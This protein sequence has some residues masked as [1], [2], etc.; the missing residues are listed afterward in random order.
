[1]RNTVPHLADDLADD[2]AGQLSD[3]TLAER[4]TAYAAEV[5]LLLDSGFAVMQRRDDLDPRVGDIVREAGLSNQ[6]FYRHF[7]GKD[8][9]LLALLTDGRRRLVET[10][11]RRMARAGGAADAMRA[12]IEAV[13]A[14]ARDPQAAA[15]TRPFAINGDRLA[16]RFPDETRRSMDRLVDPLRELVGTPNAHAVYHLAMGS[17]HDALLTRR[18]PSRAEVEHVVEFALRGCGIGT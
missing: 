17:V 10:I 3:R 2:L 14:Q 13:F 12:W 9:L 5:R 18:T 6:A 1:M 7:R 15:A 4:R 16:A 11:E 8:E